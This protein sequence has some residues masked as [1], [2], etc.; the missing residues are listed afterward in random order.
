MYLQNFHS[1]QP[2]YQKNQKECL[3]WLS[4]AHKLAQKNQEYSQ[5]DYLKMLQRVGCPETQIEKRYFFI[6]DVERSNWD[7][8]PIY[9]VKASSHGVSMHMRH[10][11][12]HKTVKEL[13]ER[14]YADRTFPDDLIH[15][16]C[17]GY[18]SPSAA[19]M[20]AVKAPKPVTVTHS[21]HMGCYGAFPALRMAS[22]F[23]ANENI[24]G[25]KL[26]VD[27]VHT[28]L[29][30]LHLNPEDPTLEQM[31]IQS[32]FADGCIAYSMSTQQP[33][34]GFKVQSLYEEL[35]PNT[36]GAMEWMVSDWGMKMSLSK[37]VP[38]MVGDKIRDFTTRWLAER[39]YDLSHVVKNGLFA[40]HPG[41]PKIIDQVV[42][43]LELKEEQ[44][45][46]S[47]ALLRQRG[48]M[49]SATLPHLWEQIL[50][51]DSVP[52]GTPIISYAFGPG[53][54]VCGSLMEKL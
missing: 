41:G 33:Q 50:R 47:R 31:V 23:L 11:Y 7:D 30:S 36:T 18:I 51:D 16:S 13:F 24:L 39:G 32:L 19:Q 26:T 54:T 17:T 25:K 49:S 15:V 28:E 2:P 4:E 12:Y 46:H 3:E 53:L 14:I 21:Y 35:I 10:E 9:P 22:G 27:L 48:N 45:A 6:P 42:K 37:D 5:E 34:K 20:T 29:C 43:H 52:S 1:I 8:K 44:V 38:M 40:V